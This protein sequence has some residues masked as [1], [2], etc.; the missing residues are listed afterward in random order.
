LAIEGC[1]QTNTLIQ[2]TLDHGASAQESV[3]SIPD[4]LCFGGDGVV[5]D[6]SG[7]DY[8]GNWAQAGN[9]LKIDFNSAY[10][11][12]LLQPRLTAHLGA[13]AKVSV[14]AASAY[15]KIRINEINS[16]LI[17][18][19]TAIFDGTG[20]AVGRLGRSGNVIVKKN[21]THSPLA[22]GAPYEGHWESIRGGAGNVFSSSVFVSINIKS[23]GSFSGRYQKYKPT[24]NA[25]ICNPRF[26]FG[27]SVWNPRG[28]AK[29]VKGY[30]NFD[31]LT[32]TIKFQGL[33]K[34]KMDVEIL[35]NNELYM[36]LP[37]GYRYAW[38]KVRR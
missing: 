29:K 9:K 22:T 6:G 36:S 10:Y 24:G 13:G 2:L 18:D 33:R 19:N 37:I 3:L 25:G 1:W 23:D 15:G 27:F 30:I 38:V 11:E 8:R 4:K 12:A 31:T 5:Y 34:V 32:G 14:G 17:L 21:A 7:I 16:E 28:P 26:C 20:T 35:S